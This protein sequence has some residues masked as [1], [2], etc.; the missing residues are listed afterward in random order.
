MRYLFCLS[1]EQCIP[2]LSRFR[3]PWLN[4]PDHVWFCN[5]FPLSASSSL[6]RKSGSRFPYEPRKAGIYMENKAH[7]KIEIRFYVRGEVIYAFRS[8]RPSTTCILKRDRKM[9]FSGW[10]MVSDDVV[11]TFT[12]RYLGDWKWIH[13]SDPQRVGPWN[14]LSLLFLARSIK[15]LYFYI[16]SLYVFPSFD[17]SLPHCDVLLKMPLRLKLKNVIVF[18]LDILRDILIRYYNLYLFIKNWLWMG[19]L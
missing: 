17:F 13:A 19:K 5:R 15:R 8:G 6:W 2:F 16:I 3:W 4:W 11:L 9:D 10:E 14:V 18:Y 7:V 1:F 12:S